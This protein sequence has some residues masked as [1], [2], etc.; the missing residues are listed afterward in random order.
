MTADG[1]GFV[2]RIS[3]KQCTQRTRVRAPHKRQSRARC[4]K[5]L[6]NF[7]FYENINLHGTVDSKPSKKEQDFSLLHS[8][9]SFNGI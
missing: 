3:L 9:T 5:N 6:T 2:N 8:P 4:A 1:G 7:C